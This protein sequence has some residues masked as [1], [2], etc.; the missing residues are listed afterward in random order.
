MELP[1]LTDPPA[2]V[3]HLGGGVYITE[4]GRWRLV[5]WRGRLLL[6]DRDGE[7][8]DGRTIDVGDDLRRARQILHAARAHTARTHRTVWI[9]QQIQDRIAP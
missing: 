8:R 7:W 2:Q 4:E 5:E 6:T 3:R 1:R 9:N